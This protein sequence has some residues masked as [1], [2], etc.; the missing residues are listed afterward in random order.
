[1]D[2]DGDDMT[3]SAVD[4]I[5]AL[6][7][8]KQEIEASVSYL[9]A[10]LAP[11]V[12]EGEATLICFPR[13][14]ESDLGS[15]A[16]K[17]VLRCGSQP[18]FWEKDL[19]WRELLR[20]ALLSKASTIIGPPIVILGLSKLAIHEGLPTSLYNAVLTGYPCL[21]WMTDGIEKGLDCK[22]W[23]IF[24][25]NTSSIVSGFSCRYGRGIHIRNDKYG[26]DIMDSSNKSVSPGQSGR[27]FLHHNLLPEV[28][29]Q[30]NA[31]GRI[32]ETACP[33]GN[34]SPKLVD[35]DAPPIDSA[36][37][38]QV[39]EELLSWNSI[40]ECKAEQSKSGLE[41]K[42]VCFKGEKLPKLPSC[43]KLVL[44]SWNPETDVPL[45]LD[46]SWLNS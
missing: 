22:T 20:I 32:Q 40:L 7:A 46:A 19:R 30:T 25:I 5:L 35:I 6:S 45:S 36:V 44:R 13:E 18:V 29:C 26:I 8:Q 37:V 41:L 39:A 38:R 17:A 21:D 43:A 15:I 14:T 9:A 27:V 16:E 24:G 28:R 11:I 2:E 4:R 33:C 23:G 31:V 12:K 1:M 3:N 34:A 10:K 42:I